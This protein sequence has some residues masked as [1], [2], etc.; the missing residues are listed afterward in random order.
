MEIWRHILESRIGHPKEKQQIAKAIGLKSPRTLDRWVEGISKPKNHHII[1]AL[2]EIIASSDM[3]E[4]LMSAFPAAF[5]FNDDDVSYQISNAGNVPLEM[6]KRVLRAYTS[7]G[8]G[9]RHWTVK[10]LVFGQMIRQIDPD[11][12]GMMLVFIQVIKD[13]QNLKI[14]VQKDGYGT[15]IWDT[16]QMISQ[17]ELAVNSF[18][19]ERLLTS[20]P[21]FC[22]CFSQETGASQHLGFILQECIQSMAIFPVMRGGKMAGGILC[23]SIQQDFFTSF[24]KE[25]MEEYAYLLGLAFTDQ[26][27]VS[28]LANEAT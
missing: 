16:R 10:N 22:Q 1:R 11:S 21:F 12:L 4:A 3:D 18:I 25:L 2:K 24:R 19:G 17:V 23:C 8:I 27:F 9:L 5:K 13:N 6:Y 14:L 20:Y 26:D 7:I 28:V 15:G